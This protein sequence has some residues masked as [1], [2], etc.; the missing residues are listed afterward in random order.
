MLE[1][2]VRLELIYESVQQSG[3]VLTT[4]SVSAQS[5]NCSLSTQRYLKRLKTHGSL[6]Q[7]ANI[8]IAQDGCSC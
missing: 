3:H 7:A 6:I 8:L 2:I 4:A 1:H 5:D